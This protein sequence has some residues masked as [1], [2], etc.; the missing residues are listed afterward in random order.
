MVRLRFRLPAF[1]LALSGGLVPTLAAQG[2]PGGPRADSLYQAQKWSEA[3]AEYARAAEAEPGNPRLWY[4]LGIAEHSQKHFDKAEKAFAGASA[5]PSPQGAGPLRGLAF[6]NL[7]AARSRQGKTDAA[8]SALESAL[9]IGRFPPRTLQGDEDFAAIKG[10]PRFAM[11]LESARLAFF[12]CDTIPHARD[13]DFW[14]GEWEVYTAVGKN[15]A[16]HSNIDRILGGCAIQE[17]W[18][19]GVGDTGKSFNWYNTVTREW[20]QTWIADQAYSTEYRKGKLEGNNLIL[21]ADSYSAQGAPVTI[22]L[23]FTNLDPNRVR[24]H[25]EQTADSGKTWVTTTDLIYVR[26]GSGVKP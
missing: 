17:N 20:Q 16:G 12:P 25:F 26:V 22:R 7:A 18:A 3:A 2:P 4:R 14:V 13:F 10:D 11:T 21:L 15:L 24:Q 6:Y 19:G 1:L 23:T 5:L 8:F 9:K